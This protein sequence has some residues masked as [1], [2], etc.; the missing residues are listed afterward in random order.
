MALNS[1]EPIIRIDVQVS[2]DIISPIRTQGQLDIFSEKISV[3]FLVKGN[4]LQ[5][6]DLHN[7]YAKILP[8]LDTLI[9]IGTGCKDDM[10]V[11]VFFPT[12]TS[13]DKCMASMRVLGYRFFDEFMNPLFQRKKKAS[14]PLPTMS[15]IT[16]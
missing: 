15:T 6:F 8:N 4:T 11:Y 12:A 10:D 2:P 13:R 16:E 5:K 7:F 14:N 1:S 3:R 9:V